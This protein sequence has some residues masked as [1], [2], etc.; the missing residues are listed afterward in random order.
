MCLAALR[1]IARLIFA[2]QW[3]TVVF[4]SYFATRLLE[5]FPG[6]AWRV[7]ARENETHK[8]WQPAY[9]DMSD[10]AFHELFCKLQDW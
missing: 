9:P 3:Q 1:A 10:G 5:G 7:Q 2:S 6:S 8:P 4:P